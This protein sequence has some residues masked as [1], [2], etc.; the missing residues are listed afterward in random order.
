VDR[1]AF[2]QVVAGL[3]KQAEAELAAEGFDPQDA[4]YTL[5]LDMLYGGL[6]HSKRTATPGLFLQDEEDV[7]KFYKRFEQ[8][9]S[10]S[11]SPL[12]VNLPGGV[13]ID[14]FV[15]KATVPS[16]KVDLV[17]RELHEADASAAQKGSRQAY[18]PG[19]KA[20]SETPV[21]DQTRLLP[22]NHIQGPA[23]IE[24]EYTTIV[25]PSEMSYRVDPYGLGIM[26]SA[27]GGEV[28]ADSHRRTEAEVD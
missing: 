9:F 26:S 1:D 4:I 23:I 3:K 15:L 11:F 18:W 20:W 12:V 16:H 27:K 17:A 6:I 25:I 19:L 13:Y 21:Y 8:E 14:T 22:G 7:W 28:N 24:S 5:E 10:E 2:N